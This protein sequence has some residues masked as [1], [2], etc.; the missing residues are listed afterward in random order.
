VFGAMLKSPFADA[1]WPIAGRTEL[2]DTLSFPLR[3]SVASW[4]GTAVP[5]L[6]ETCDR[7]H[8]ALHL[9]TS[10]FDFSA[11]RDSNRQRIDRRIG[12]NKPLPT[13]AEK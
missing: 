10:L 12:D 5:R 11:S 3:H 8:A 6:T 7:S 9:P 4:E 1:R 2:P 13:D